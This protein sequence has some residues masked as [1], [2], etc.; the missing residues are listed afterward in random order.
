MIVDMLL[1][2]LLRMSETDTCWKMRAIAMTPLCMS[3]LSDLPK[4]L[5]QR[6][7]QIPHY[8]NMNVRLLET[9][10][11]TCAML[12][13]VPNMALKRDAGKPRKV[14]S[15]ALRRLLEASEREVLAGP[16]QNLNDYISVATRALGKGDYEKAFETISSLHTW[17]LMRNWESVLEMLKTKM[18]EAALRAYL[19]SHS[20]SHE[21]L[22]L[23]RLG[24]AFD[25]SDSEM[26]GVIDKM[27]ATDEV[28][29]RL[30]SGCMVFYYVQH[31]SVQALSSQLEE[32]L[33]ATAA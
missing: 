6:R 7:Q 22:D 9:I 4:D 25:L 3:M 28:H 31:R 5:M 23:D 18:K 27:L 24:R 14:I 32:K 15:K 26:R 12:L 29:A 21:S 11:L 2:P 17:K 16:P 8:M 19:L 20:S 33:S 10:H 13:E 30:D 1:C